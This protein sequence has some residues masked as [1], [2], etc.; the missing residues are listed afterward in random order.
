MERG[1]ER[2]VSPPPGLE[3]RLLDGPVLLA[4]EVAEEALDLAEDPVVQRVELRAVAAADLAVHLGGDPLDQPPPL[5]VLLVHP[6]CAH[7]SIAA[8]SAS[9]AFSRKA[10][11]DLR[12]RSMRER[13]HWVPALRGRVVD[14]RATKPA[15]SSARS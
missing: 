5:G 3:P 7:V 13:K 1:A 11:R 4:V 2:E 10:W 12:E 6:A 8:A 15:T 9:P 14:V